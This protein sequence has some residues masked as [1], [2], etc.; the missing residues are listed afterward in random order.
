[1][2]TQSPDTPAEV[3]AF[4]LEGLR[5]M[6]PEQRFFAAL[7]LSSAARQIALAGIRARHGSQL[8]ERELLLHYASLF[9]DRETMVKAFGWDPR[10]R[11]L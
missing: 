6:T 11:G 9:L 3:E 7:D 4:W 2:R 5:R 1:M 8:S 10:E